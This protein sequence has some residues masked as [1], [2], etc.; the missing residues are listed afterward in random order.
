M[1]T[2][3]PGRSLDARDRGHNT[4]VIARGSAGQD[5]AAGDF[6]NTWMILQG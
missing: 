2:D 1:V 6:D 3:V 4:P 5:L